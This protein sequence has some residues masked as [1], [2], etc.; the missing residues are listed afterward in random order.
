MQVLL[1]IVFFNFWWFHTC[2]HCD[3]VLGQF[4]LIVPSHSCIPPLIVSYF[5]SYI[6]S[7]CFILFVSVGLAWVAT[8]TVHIS[9]NSHVLS[10]RQPLTE[11][12]H[13]LWTSF[14]LS[15]LQ[16]S[17]GLQEVIYIFPTE[18][19]GLNCHLFL[20]LGQLCVF[21]SITS[22]YKTKFLWPRLRAALI[23]R[24]IHNCVDYLPS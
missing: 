10:R 4:L 7:F 5:P 11:F 12:L 14:L 6:L 17:C 8:A 23:Y 1:L 20:A 19:W 2:I 21:A 24:K 13:I 22:H 15:L 16:Y 18:G 3:V 9:C